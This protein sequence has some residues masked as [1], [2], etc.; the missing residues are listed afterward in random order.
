[1][2]QQEVGCLCC[3]CLPLV[4]L[5]SITNLSDGLGSSRQTDCATL[6]LQMAQ[7]AFLPWISPLFLLVPLGSPAFLDS[8]FSVFVLAMFPSS[9]HLELQLKGQ[10]NESN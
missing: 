4:D 9:G 5:G 1:M 2:R 7:N 3:R 8:W 6:L 10:C